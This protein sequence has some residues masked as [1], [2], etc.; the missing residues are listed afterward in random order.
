MNK[1]PQQQDAQFCQPLLPYPYYKKE[2]SLVDLIKI[3]VRRRKLMITVFTF[4]FSVSS[5]FLFLYT[6]TKYSYTTLYNTAEINIGVPLESNESLLSKVDNIYIPEQVRVYLKSEKLSELPFKIDVTTPL[7]TNLVKLT[8]LA[9]DE[10]RELV[11][12]LHESIIKQ[13]QKQQEVKT[14]K[15][16]VLLQ[17]RLDAAKQQLDFILNSSSD[18]AGEIAASLMSTIS[19]LESNISSIS[20]GDLAT[21]TTR[22]LK[23]VNMSKYLFLLLILIASGMLSIIVTFTRELANTVHNSINS[24]DKS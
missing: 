2:L 16:I 23:S 6:P 18:K 4:L 14:D 17:Q 21:K 24:N 13:L 20:P 22:S 11:E 1:T 8:S 10:D 12:L 3:L 5:L 15:R 9:K 19:G 7:D